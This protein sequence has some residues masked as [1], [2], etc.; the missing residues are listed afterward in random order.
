M[1]K[2]DFTDG[3]TMILQEHAQTT[4]SSSNEQQEEVIAGYPLLSNEQVNLL[5]VLI[6]TL[7]GYTCGFIFY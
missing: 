7:F 4:A 1:C 2:H 6:M 3:S 5:S